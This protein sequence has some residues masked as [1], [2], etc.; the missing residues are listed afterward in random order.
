[1]GDNMKVDDESQATVKKVGLEELVD[2]CGSNLIDQNSSIDLVKN[3]QVSM[4][5]VVG[6][7]ELSVGELFDLKDGSVIDIDRDASE[8]LDL[9][10]DGKVVA[11]GYLVAAGDNFGI[12]IVDKE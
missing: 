11:K 5:V 12:Q 1:M 4:D 2:S 7:A 10:L 8:P 6:K 3:V 9:M